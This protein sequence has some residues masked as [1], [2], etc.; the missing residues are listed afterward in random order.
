MGYDIVS[1]LDELRTT[2]TN[3]DVITIAHVVESAHSTIGEDGF[4]AKPISV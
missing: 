1:L 4:V 3:D 2:G